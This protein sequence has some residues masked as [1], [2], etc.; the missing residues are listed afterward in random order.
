M[1]ACVLLDFDG[2]KILTDPWFSERVLYH[3]GEPRSV[4]G[5]ADLPRL[6]GILISHAHYD[7]CDLG[8]LAGYPDKD[9]AGSSHCDGSV[10]P[11]RHSPVGAQLVPEMRTSQTSSASLAA[12]A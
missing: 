6:D 3:Q 1:H 12:T 11:V 2:A 4:A 5:P 10:I 9:P 7:H 8:A